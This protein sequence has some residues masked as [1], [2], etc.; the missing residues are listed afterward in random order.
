[1]FR[2]YI[3]IYIYFLSSTSTFNIFRSLPNRPLQSLP[4]S[5]H[6][7]YHHRNVIH[8]LRGIFSVFINTLLR[9]YFLC[10]PY[11][12]QCFPRLVKNL[13]LSLWP[14]CSISWDYSMGERMKGSATPATV[15]VRHINLNPPHCT[16]PAC[17]T[18]FAHCTLNAPT[19]VTLA[20]WS[21]PFLGH[22]RTCV[23]ST[24]YAATIF[25]AG[26]VRVGVAITSSSVPAIRSCWLLHWSHWHKK[27]LLKD[28]EI[29]NYFWK[30]SQDVAAGISS[31]H[32]PSPVAVDI[33]VLFATFPKVVKTFPALPVLP[34]LMSD[35]ILMLCSIRIVYR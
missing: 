19:L 31:R 3:R 8:T 28:G 10:P 35:S 5:F 24:N 2:R 4:H 1:M 30:R 14:F 18:F 13:R 11:T 17:A 23:V 32:Y 29:Y 21:I 33:A 12:A 6:K 22:T 15:F 7:H 9:A 20:M 25:G 27:T 26:G 34:R 16:S